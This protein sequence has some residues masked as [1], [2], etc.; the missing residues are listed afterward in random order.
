MAYFSVGDR[1]QIYGLTDTEFF[2]GFNGGA[3]PGHQAELKKGV[4][5]V[6]V[7]V[8]K[9]NLPGAR[10]ENLQ[11]VP[12][13]PCG[14]NYYEGND[15]VI[16]GNFTGCYFSSYS[17]RGQRRVAHVATDIDAR[18]NCIAEFSRLLNI[19]YYSAGRHYKPFR[20]FGLAAMLNEESLSRPANFSV[21]KYL[22]T[23]A[24]MKGNNCTTY[25]VKRVSDDAYEVIFK[26]PLAHTNLRER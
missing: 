17:Y 20:A 25:C 12:F 9:N 1:L 2:R 15:A 6:T 14:I 13:V 4:R 22:A 11:W 26:S 7:A 24:V 18:K 21:T 5:S 10:I 3:S 23:I 16:S 8:T 19:P